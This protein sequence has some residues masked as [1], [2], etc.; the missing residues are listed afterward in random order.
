MPDDV[1]L[2]SSEETSP[3]AAP[4]VS[5]LFLDV[6]QGDCTV[7]IDHESK[8]ALV[9]DCPANKERVLQRL[10]CEQGVALDTAIVTHYDSD[11]SVGVV[12]LAASGAARRFASRVIQHE[13]PHVAAQYRDLVKAKRRGMELL[14]VGVGDEGTVGRLRWSLI[15]PLQDTILSAASIAAPASPA[16]RR[17]RTSLIVR[18]EVKFDVVSDGVLPTRSALV[19]GDADSVSWGHQLAAGNELNAD[20][21]RWPHHGGELGRGPRSLGARLLQAV[22]PEAIFIGVGSTNRYGHPKM[23]VVDRVRGDSA[24][25]YCS[26]VTELC[27]LSRETAAVPC[28]GTVRIDVASDGS[29]VF[30][31]PRREHERGVIDRWAQ[32]V[33]MVA[34]AQPAHGVVQLG[35]GEVV[36]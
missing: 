32:P 30:D 34:S 11:H 10:L 13:A 31:P 19:A 35:R 18:I 17:N 14:D 25:L 15:G 16:R 7:V 20:L 5:F 27:S 2:G 4:I 26:E 3:Q 23:E 28:S 6:G 22:A 9:V 33:C 24:T 29:L 12:D 8:Q 21:F 1:D 36:V